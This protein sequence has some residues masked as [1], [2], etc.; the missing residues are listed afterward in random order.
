MFCFNFS[1]Y[2]NADQMPKLNVIVLFTAIF[3][4]INHHYA[5]TIYNNGWYLRDPVFYQNVT[6]MSYQNVMFLKLPI[7]I[8]YLWMDTRNS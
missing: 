7:H 8:I 4:S 3:M 5:K 6:K 2:K 1:L